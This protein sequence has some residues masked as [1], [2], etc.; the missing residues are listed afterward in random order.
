MTMMT[1]KLND[2]DWVTIEQ[3]AIRQIKEHV[4]RM[5]ADA[6]SCHEAGTTMIKNDV[7]GNIVEGVIIELVCLLREGKM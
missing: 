4:L 1:R 7:V 5:A 3:A 2:D 6:S